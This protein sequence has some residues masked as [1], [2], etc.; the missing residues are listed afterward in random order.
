[1]D[2]V[3]SA[4]AINPEM[5]KS[6][7]AYLGTIGVWSLV[8]WKSK[9]PNIVMMLNTEVEYMSLS[10]GA[11]D[12]TFTTHLLDEIYYIDLPAVIAEENTKAIFLS[13]NQQV[14]SRTKHIDVK[15]HIFCEKVES[16]HFMAL[17][18]QMC[19]KSQ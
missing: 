8:T 4:F 2:V 3:D 11:K 10:D 15:H 12:T 9:G 18:V 1:M 5:Q 16:S 6:I 7:C 14:G 17:Y 13:K 19:A